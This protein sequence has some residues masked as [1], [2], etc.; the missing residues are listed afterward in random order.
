MDTS[1]SSSDE[2]DI[3]VRQIR[4]HFDLGNLG[5][6]QQYDNIFAVRLPNIFAIRIPRFRPYHH[7]IQQH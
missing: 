4:Q 2:Y 5:M 3:D 6:Q 7:P 1:S